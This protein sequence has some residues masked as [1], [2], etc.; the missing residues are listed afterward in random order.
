MTLGSH[1]KEI[2][3]GEGSENYG[4]FNTSLFKWIQK[5]YLLYYSGSNE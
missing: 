3:G 4:D 2:L 5:D 1:Y